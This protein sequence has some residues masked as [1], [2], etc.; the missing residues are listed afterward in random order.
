M[1]RTL[2]DDPR[3]GPAY[4]GLFESHVTV[5]ARSGE[6]LG[7]FREVCGAIGGKAVWIVLPRGA[8]RSQPMAN[9]VYRGTLAGAKAEAAEVAGPRGSRSSGSRSRPIPTTATSRRP[10]PT[11]RSSARLRR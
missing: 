2:R 6:E 7:R 1:T 10:T 5:D 8:A 11:R 4:A 9:V 3:A